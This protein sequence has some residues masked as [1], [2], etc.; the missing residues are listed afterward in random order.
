MSDVGLSDFRL[1]LVL[2]RPDQPQRPILPVLLDGESWRKRTTVSD[3]DVLPVEVLRNLMGW[4]MVARI[5]WP[6]WLQNRREVIDRVLAEVDRAEA[7]LNGEA[8][9]SAGR[10]APS[11]RRIPPRC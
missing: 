9:E 2:S 1:D 11:A 6:T 8:D 3:R 10:L 7:L 4:P 5:W